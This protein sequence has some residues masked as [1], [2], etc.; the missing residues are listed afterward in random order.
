MA[1]TRPTTQMSPLY[2]ARDGLLVQLMPVCLVEI[3][4]KQVKTIVLSASSC[5]IQLRMKED[6]N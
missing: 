2:R 3:C 5:V 4:V 1:L 6:Q